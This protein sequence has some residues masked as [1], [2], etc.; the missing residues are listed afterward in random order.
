MEPIKIICPSRKRADT[1]LTKIDNMVLIV[2]ENELDD[3]KKYN[4]CEIITHPN[5]N[6]LSLIRQYIYEKFGDVFMIDDDIV[7][8]QR[9]YTTKKQDLN[10]N[11]IYNIIQNAYYIA[12]QINAKIFGFNNDPNPTH[13]TAQKPFMLSGYINGCSFGILKD[14]HLYFTEKTT[15]AESHWINLLNYYYNRF[16]FID[17]RF[18]FRQK[19]NST[20]TLP[21][22]QTGIRTLETEKKDTIFLRKMFGNSVNVKKP[23]NK[24]VQL[25]EYQR[26]LKLKI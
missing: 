16:S 2:A 18:H 1:V 23:K 24:T 15:A 9:L 20:F 19:A 10:P 11:E 21:G 8:V 14:K 6:K 25:H 7:K 22:G 26:I 13:Y 5:L 3:Y 12:S 17:K 4:D